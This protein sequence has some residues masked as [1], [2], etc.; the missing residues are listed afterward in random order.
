MD[1]LSVAGGVV[2][3]ISLSIQVTQGLVDFYSAH[4]G[5]QSDLAHTA[6]KLEHLLRTL[7]ILHD[8]LAQRRFSAEEKPL[9]KNVEGSIQDC[10]ECI[11]ELQNEANK[12]KDNPTNGI[13]ATART[14]ARKVA[15]PF[16]QSTLQALDED[17]DE[18]VS[19][20]SLA[21]QVLQHTNTDQVLN[22]IEDTK[23]LLSLVRAG[24]ISS[25]TRD[26]LKAPDATINYNDACKKRHPSTGLWLVKDS[27]FSAW[28]TNP[29]SF[30]W[31][32]GF[33]GCGKSVLC[34]TAVQSVFRHRRSDP[35]TG[36][37]FFFFTF[38][39]DAKQD[40]S[41]ML[42]ALVLQLSGQADDNHELLSRLRKS[43]RDAMPPD[44]ALMGCLR[45][46]V[47]T[48][49][50]TY[51]ILDALD[52]SPRDTYRGEML[53]ALSE[54]R[55]W[56]EPGLHLLVTSREEVDIRDELCPAG[57]ESISMK[58]DSVDRDIAAFISSHLTNNRRLRKWQEQRAHIEA[59]LTTRAKGV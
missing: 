36:L 6:K 4:K 32:Y 20:L 29:N 56:S 48:F 2:G 3:I 46:L 31:L 45:Q 5:R 8:K 24:Q 44:Q 54:I 35:R 39:D 14:A 11:H 37:A 26:W 27:S 10:E 43:Y 28:L 42:R 38:N 52:E 9:L 17:V 16:R 51:I 50:N 1:P 12:F 18:I 55:A 25:A 13:R 57:N 7:E 22:D 21:L 33:A 41:A 19:H 30:L 40:T 59:A 15:Y 58:N 34:S 49:D 47:R 53:Q 23:A